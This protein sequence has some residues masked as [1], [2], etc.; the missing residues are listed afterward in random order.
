MR[1][2]WTVWT[3]AV[4]AYAVAVFDRSSL[5]VAGPAAQ[6]RF[7]ASAAELSLLAV[8]QL[9][10]YAALQIPVGL[11]LDRW[12]SRRMIVAGALVMGVGQVALALAGGIPAAVAARVLVGVGDAMTFISVLRL[13]PLWFAPRRVP[14]L[15]QVTGMLGQLG[16][17]AAAVPLVALLD[18]VG[19]TNAYLGVA[20]V[21]V[22]VVA[23]V[24]AGLRDAP[25]GTLVAPPR[26]LGDVRRELRAA[27]SEPGTRLGLWTHFVTPFSGL[28]FVMLWG[29][30]FLVSGQGLAPG[31]AGVLLS[32]V[33]LVSVAV[34]PVLG[35]LTGQWPLRRSAL[36]FA[37]AGSSAAAWTAV[38]LWPGTAPFWLLVTLV[39]V[40]GGNGPGSLI[41]FDYARTTNP[42]GRLGSANGIVNVG[43]FVSGLLTILAVGAVLDVVS[44]GV[45]YTTGDFRLAFA[46]QYPLWVIGLLGVVRRR[47]ELRR[48]M[49]ERDGIV[50]DPLHRAVRR[51]FARR[52]VRRT[53]RDPGRVRHPK[54]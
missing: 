46:V 1:R 10:V 42:A 19:W 49:R 24:L 34:G 43:G 40:L 2:A 9:A 23:V 28:A 15:T 7:G 22:V 3:V 45:D 21:S 50:I 53:L 31:T 12:G 11:L 18:G 51:R 6:E 44:D 52:A 38:L 36:V 13:I 41:G 26:G 39:V 25:A 20:A 48:R 35:G 30:P 16:Q 27:W 33:V 4:V 8:L 54:E 32:V 29:Y 14:V 17:V 47:R 37:I 5:S